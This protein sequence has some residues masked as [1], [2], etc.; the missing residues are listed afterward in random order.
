MQTCLKTV[1]IHLGNYLKSPERAALSKVGEELAETILQ[2]EGSALLLYKD[3]A[4]KVDNV[5]VLGLALSL[6]GAGAPRRS[7][8]AVVAGLLCGGV[9]EGGAGG[10]EAGGLGGS[11]GDG[12]AGWGVRTNLLAELRGW[13]IFC[14]RGDEGGVPGGVGDQTGWEGGGGRSC[15]E[16]EEEER[17]H[18]GESGN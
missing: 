9:G 14:E 1:V 17:G 3:V 12:L 18:G 5:P 2:A 11:P 13:D 6:G 8:D 4:K 10:G 7:G 16:Q 15:L